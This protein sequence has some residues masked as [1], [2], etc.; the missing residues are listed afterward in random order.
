MPTHAKLILTPV[1]VYI[2]VLFWVAGFVTNPPLLGW[3]GFVVV[4]A[5]GLAVAGFAIWLYPR[6]RVNADHVHPDVGAGPKLLV[7]ADA[8]CASPAFATAV[9]SVVHG[10]TAEVYVVAPVLPSPLGFLTESEHADTE[11]ARAR[12]ADALALL[13][14]H[15]IFAR[16]LVGGDDP[17]QAIG[18]ALA[19]FPATEIV[20]V[21]SAGSRTWLEQG[22]AHRAR[23]VFGVHVTTVSEPGYS[24]A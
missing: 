4:A 17:L 12:L 8:H 11:D 3:I 7:L 5:V 10:R 14:H 21:E 19:T 13:G 16:G 1:L 20:V 18:D 24:V 9:K 22:L 2:V 23:D 15:G 6:S